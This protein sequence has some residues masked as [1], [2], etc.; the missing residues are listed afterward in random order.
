MPRDP[1]KPRGGKREA[2][3]V[4]A[5]KRHISEGLDPEDLRPSKSL[6]VY[7]I[8]VVDDSE[9]QQ[10]QAAPRRNPPACFFPLPPQPPARDYYKIALDYHGC[11]DDGRRDGRIPQHNEA[12]VKEL[13]QADFVPWIL[14]YIGQGGPHS[15]EREDT[16]HNEASLLASSCN[17]DPAP[18]AEPHSSGIYV[19]VCR[20]RKAERSW[21]E[22]KGYEASRRDTLVAVDDRCEIA[23]DYEAYGVV[24]YHVDTR[25]KPFHSKLPA[26]GEEHASQPSF[27]DAIH[28]VI[29]D[30]YSGALARKISL[31]RQH[32][33]W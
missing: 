30:S 10:Q 4:E 28:S 9:Q 31:L 33:G 21:E 7:D 1:T 19:L 2:R 5:V 26:L 16:L 22:G 27:L 20:K 13:I 23:A 8:H 17:L 24:C 3:R 6:D 29:E 18:K 32:R 25:R 14:S 15:Q 12:A 11:L